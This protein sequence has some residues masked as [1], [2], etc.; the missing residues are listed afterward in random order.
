MKSLYSIVSGLLIGLMLLVSPVLSQELPS[1][2]E[3]RVQVIAQ[4]LDLD[5]DSRKAERLLQGKSEQIRKGIEALLFDLEV[6]ASPDSKLHLDKYSIELIDP[7]EAASTPLSPWGLLIGACCGD[8]TYQHCYESG[9][10]PCA[11]H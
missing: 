11:G 1:G 7:T 2:D 4:D 3:A 9:C 8:G 6:T 10:D 5:S